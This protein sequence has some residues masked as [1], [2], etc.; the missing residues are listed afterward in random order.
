[1]ASAIQLLSQALELGP[2][3]SVILT[4]P[5][6]DEATGQYVREFRVFFPGVVNDD[7]TIEQEILVFTARVFA[8]ELEQL[9]VVAPSQPF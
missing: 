9:A 3:S 5:E 4:P 2:C 1:M 7:G 6:L 8:D